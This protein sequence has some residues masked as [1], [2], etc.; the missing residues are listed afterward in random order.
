[1]FIIVE[2]NVFVNPIAVRLFGAICIM[3]IPHDCF[4]LIH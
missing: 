2:K 3:M 4:N 1:M